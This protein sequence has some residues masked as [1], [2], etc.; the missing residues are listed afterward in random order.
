[1]H[2]GDLGKGKS[3]HQIPLATDEL[4]KI[5]DSDTINQIIDIA[6]HAIK[7][8]RSDSSALSED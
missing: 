5:R 7:L 8:V 4:H 2:L 6:P 3:K 1:M